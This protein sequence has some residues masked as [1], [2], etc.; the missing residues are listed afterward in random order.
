MDLEKQSH[1]GDDVDAVILQG[2]P[3]FSTIFSR[4][5]AYAASQGEHRIGVSICGPDAMVMDATKACRE[6]NQKAIK[7]DAHFEVFNL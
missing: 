4:I 3:D 6:T 1:L 2:R 5:H 7:W